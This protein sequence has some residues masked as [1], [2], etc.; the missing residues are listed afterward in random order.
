[1]VFAN[2]VESVDGIWRVLE[3]AGVK[4]KRYHRDLP[5]DERAESLQ[6]FEQDGGLLICTDS[7]ARGLDI[8]NIGHIIQVSL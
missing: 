3:R 1:M 6:V 8:P 4:S 7:A 2:S 5:L